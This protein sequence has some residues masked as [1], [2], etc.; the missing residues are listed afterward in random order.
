MKNKI[1]LGLSII[2]R[3]IFVLLI[4]IILDVACVFIIN[5][6]LFALRRDNVYEG[7]FFNVYD[8]DDDLEIKSKRSKFSCSE[9]KL[10]DYGI[11]RLSVKKSESCN[12]ELKL[13]FD[14]ERKVYLSCIDEVYV[15]G[16]SN[17][18]NKLKDF[19]DNDITKLDKILDNYDGQP[20][21]DGGSIS[22]TIRYRGEIFRVDR[23]HKLSGNYNIY[24]GNKNMKFMCNRE[25]D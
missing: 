2:L 22:Y 18:N 6:P 25:N 15:D 14:G 5:R 24:I 3:V 19:M 23:C 17:V 20:Y 21:N 9:S 10:I 8:C 1:K 7:L 13:Y 11:Y 4:I 12:N 16:D